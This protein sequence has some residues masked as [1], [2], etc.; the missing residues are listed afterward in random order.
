M[1]KNIV[2][3]ILTIISNAAICQ[4]AHS[5]L[6]LTSN[7]VNESKFY[8][9]PLKI[10]NQQNSR[11][12][13]N[14][15][16]SGDF[17]SEREVYIIPS[18]GNSI[19]LKPISVPPNPDPETN[20]GS[21]SIRGN[22]GGGGIPPSDGP[23][24]LY[25]S[26]NQIK[27][28]KCIVNTESNFYLYPNPTEKEFTIVFLKELLYS[29]KIFDSNGILKITEEFNKPIESYT[30]NTESLSKGQYIIKI[31]TNNQKE[32]TKQFIKK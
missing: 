15:E 30:I 28:D 23:I 9:Q 20:G 29:Y 16:I 21:S 32:L 11:S 17:F 18:D 8:L 25:V 13:Q 19:V 31:I 26:R 27:T 3:F 22:A 14:I 5:N 10:S 12:V 24:V 2:L 7:L 6:F 1:K 4:I